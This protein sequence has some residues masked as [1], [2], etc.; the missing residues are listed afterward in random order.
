MGA[1]QNFIRYYANE[2][3]QTNC[4]QKNTENCPTNQKN[5]TNIRLKG[6]KAFVNFRNCCRAFNFQ[7]DLIKYFVQLNEGK[8]FTEIMFVWQYMEALRV[9]ENTGKYCENKLFLWFLSQY[10]NVSHLRSLRKALFKKAQI[11][12]RG[13]IIFLY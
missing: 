12:L 11:V 13:S 6:F 9:T 5:I 7:L 1:L 8:K 4:K 3:M 2:I 10:K